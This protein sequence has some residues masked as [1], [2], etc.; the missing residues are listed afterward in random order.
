MQ[1]AKLYRMVQEFDLGVVIKVMLGRILES[2]VPLIW[3]TNSK[4]FYNYLL[5]LSTTQNKQLMV[6]I[7]SLHQLYEQ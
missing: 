6:D 1:T 5:K 4:S 7:I 2:I 3:Y